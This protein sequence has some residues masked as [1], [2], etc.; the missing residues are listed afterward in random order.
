MIGAAYALLMLAVLAC[1]LSFVAP[2]WLLVPD[3]T[4]FNPKSYGNWLTNG[5]SEGLFAN[6]YHA[7]NAV[8]ASC[9]WFWENNFEWERS[10]EGWL[11]WL[12]F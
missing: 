12:Q 1:G 9:K 3:T 8:K 5:L 7:D 2:F 11:Q 6:C 4:W 10:R